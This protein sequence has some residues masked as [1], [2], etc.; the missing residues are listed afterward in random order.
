MLTTLRVWHLSCDTSGCYAEVDATSG[1]V[2][3]DRQV[4]TQA[5]ALVAFRSLGWAVGRSHRC[6][7][8]RR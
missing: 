5:D 6:P 2:F 4:W 3:G 7:T 8:H 1:D